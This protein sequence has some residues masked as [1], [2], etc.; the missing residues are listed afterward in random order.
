M[1]RP[2]KASESSD[3]NVQRLLQRLQHHVQIGDEA[4]TRAISDEL[5]A[6]GFNEYRA[7]DAE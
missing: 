7:E 2:M 3:P 4:R 5:V 6:A 1:T